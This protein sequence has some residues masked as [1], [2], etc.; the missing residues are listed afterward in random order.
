MEI[1]R[2]IMAALGPL[3]LGLAGTLSPANAQQPDLVEHSAAG[4]MSIAI[5]EGRISGSIRNC[6]LGAVLEEIGS[7]SGLPL[8]AAD[9]IEVQSARVSAEL[10]RVPLDEGLRQLLKD[11]DTFFYYGAVGN[12]SSSLRAVWIYRKGTAAALRPVPPEAWAGVKELRASLADFD[13][14]VRGRAYE[15]LIS[16]PD[17]ESRELVIQALR[18]A[19]EPDAAVRERI[20]SSAFSTGMALPPDLL[21]DLARWDG[22]EGIR[23]MALDALA[24][25]P[26]WVEVARA[27]LTDSSELVRERAKQILAELGRR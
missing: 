7:R 26:T 8:I 4:Q 15:A 22:S 14:E 5:E 12:A 3:L 10:A 27:A 19:V 11:Y 1:R 13:P 20:L 21:T 9:D 25:E 16:R 18:G 23:L 24:T 2:S 6:V 17:R